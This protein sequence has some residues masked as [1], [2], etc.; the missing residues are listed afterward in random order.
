MVLA[1]CNLNGLSAGKGASTEKPFPI[2]ILELLP[3]Q[4]A[5]ITHATMTRCFWVFIR[6]SGF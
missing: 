4:A 3:E 5:K 2:A 1:G 6:V